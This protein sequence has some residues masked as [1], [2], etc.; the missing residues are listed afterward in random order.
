M[1]EAR[2]TGIMRKSGI[3]VF[4]LVALFALAALA[5]GCGG[6]NGATTSSAIS[7]TT[8][9]SADSST[10]TSAASTDSTIVAG[11]KTHADYEAELPDLQKAVAAN[12]GDLASLQELAVAQYQ[13]SQY[14]DAVATYN[15][16]LAISNDAFTRNNLGNVYRDWGKADEAKAEYETAISLDPTYRRLWTC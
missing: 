13:L 7:P 12:P 9:A 1:K 14:E 6:S 8:T 3:A 11:G 2:M 5:A 15:K 10:A 4:V 16:M